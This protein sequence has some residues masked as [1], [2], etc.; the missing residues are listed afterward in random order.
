MIEDALE[1]DEEPKTGSRKKLICHM[2]N[3]R[4]WGFR[5]SQWSP[6]SIPIIRVKNLILSFDCQGISFYWRN[7]FNSFF[8]LFLLLHVISIINCRKKSILITFFSFSCSTTLILYALYACLIF[9]GKQPQD[10]KCC[11]IQSD[12]AGSN[13]SILDWCLH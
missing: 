7:H 10:P 12:I 9:S 5:L 4:R 2:W 1:D 6:S 8:S 3:E 11:C 13:S